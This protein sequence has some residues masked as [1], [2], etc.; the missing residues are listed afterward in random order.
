MNVVKTISTKII[1][2]VRFIKFLRMGKSDVRECRQIAPYGTDSNP[3]KDM[4]AIYS[5]TQEDGKNVILGYVNKNQ[6]A[7]EG[8]HRIFSTD[9]DGV[10]QT[11]IW[12]RNGKSIMEIGGDSDFM[13][14]YSKLE[15]AFN[16]L[17]N[18]FNELV[19]TFNTHVHPSPAGGSTGSTPTPGNSSSA[20]ISGAKIKEIKTL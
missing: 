16:E 11:Y 2:G 12:L 6:I 10:V 8:E 7:A 13:V 4:V 19:S 18:D 20:D 17:K 5:P 1:K 3:I 9:S 15:T 14:R